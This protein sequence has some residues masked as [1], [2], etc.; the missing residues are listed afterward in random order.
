MVSD[1]TTNDRPVDVAQISASCRLRSLTSDRRT[2]RRRTGGATYNRTGKAYR[3]GAIQP[4]GHGRCGGRG[5]RIGGPVI[6]PADFYRYARFP[7]A[8]PFLGSSGIHLER[9]PPKARV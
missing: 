6:A 1:G 3:R 5:P 4:Y 7:W 8:C 2:W 9:P